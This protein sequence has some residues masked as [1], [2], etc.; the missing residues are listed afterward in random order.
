M[1]LGA[2]K[3]LD[4]WPVRLDGHVETHRFTPFA[5]GVHDCCTFA[6][7]SVEAVIGID[8]LEGLRWYGQ[9]GALRQ[10]QLEGGLLMAVCRRLNRAPIDW[11]LAQRGDLVLL[12]S[13]QSEHRP[14]GT[15]LGI[16]LGEVCAVPGPQGLVFTG[17]RQAARAWPIGRPE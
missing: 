14:S 4:H 8:P 6:S 7:G 10:L 17:M 15:S 13:E 2:V 1:S 12:E 9:Y 16:C 5:W 3:R 11:E